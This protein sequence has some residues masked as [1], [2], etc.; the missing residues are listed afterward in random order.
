MHIRLFIFL[1]LLLLPYCSNRAMSQT[2]ENEIYKVY[3]VPSLEVLKMNYLADIPYDEAS[4][5]LSSLF[6]HL[7]EVQNG[8]TNGFH[9]H[10]VKDYL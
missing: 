10:L 5:T 8:K 6:T 3:C 9:H 1:E 4:D 7:A 2:S